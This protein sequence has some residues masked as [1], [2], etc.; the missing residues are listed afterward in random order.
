MIWEM[1]R[2]SF[3]KTPFSTRGPLLCC[4]ISTHGCASSCGITQLNSHTI[5]IRPKLTSVIVMMGYIKEARYWSS[6]KPRWLEDSTFAT[7]PS[8]VQRLGRTALIQ[9]SWSAPSAFGVT[10]SVYKISN[11]SAMTLRIYVANWLTFQIP[12]DI[13]TMSSP[14]SLVSWINL[15]I[16]LHSHH[17]SKQF[18]LPSMLSSHLTKT[19]GR[20]C[21]RCHSSSHFDSRFNLE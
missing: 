5:H 21:C 17:G 12:S 4:I 3:Y 2:P 15:I 13:P 16:S 18:K 7:R 11:V 9:I 19:S 1:S 10:E 8:E 6:Q 20:P 14:Y